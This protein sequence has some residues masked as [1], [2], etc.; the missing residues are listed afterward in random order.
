ML[1]G[2][3]TNHHLSTLK[4]ILQCGVVHTSNL[5]RYDLLLLILLTGTLIR[6]RSLIVI[7]PRWHRAVTCEV[8]QITTM[9]TRVVV[10]ACNLSQAS[11]PAA[12]VK[13]V[14]PTAAI[15]VVA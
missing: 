8:P 11:A 12:V 14:V 3:H 4:N 2:K 9:V 15:A 13:D 10:G 7:L 5:S 1:N 6:C